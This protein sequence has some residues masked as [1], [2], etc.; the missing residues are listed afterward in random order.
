MESDIVSPVSAR[1][2]IDGTGPQHDPTMA[3]AALVSMVD[4]VYCVDTAGCFTFANTAF[5]AMTGYALADLR[6]TPSTHRYVPEAEVLFRERRRQVYSGAPVP[7][8]VETVLLLKDGRR[9]PVEVSVSSLIM[10]GHVVGRVGVLRDITERKAAEAAL[11]ESEERLRI[12]ARQ[13]QAVA[14]LG[15]LAL[16][17]R[18]LQTVFTHAVATV[19]ETLAVDY[20]KV[21]ELLPEGDATAV[22]RRGRLAG[23]ARRHGDGQR[24]PP[25]P[26]G[27][28]P[29]VRY[30]GGRG[31]SAPGAAL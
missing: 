17:E 20:C 29:A 4:A 3:Y 6:G 31:G 11:R 22:A 28:H 2:A 13:Q 15:E 16:R 8:L 12:R 26:G 9:L 18:A 7:P 30:P 5:E 21:L 27:L 1:H 25:F 24:R 19:A 14:Q 10:E 23:R